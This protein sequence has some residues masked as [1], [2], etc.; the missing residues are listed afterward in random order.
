MDNNENMSSKDMENKKLILIPKIEDYIEYMLNVI[1]KLPR[2]E[3]FSIGNEYKTSMYSMLENSLYTAKINRKENIKETLKLLNK[4]DA[5]LNCQRIFLRILK[6]QKWI[7]EKKFDVAMIKIYE[8]GK[9][10][11]G[12]IKANAKNYKERIW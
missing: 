1:I 12:I 4:I 11:G 8:I 10:V 2:V 6:K 3:K 5:E 7:D 9:I